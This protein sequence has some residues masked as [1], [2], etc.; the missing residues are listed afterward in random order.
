MTEII[1][2]PVEEPGC[3]CG[4][5]LALLIGLVILIIIALPGGSDDSPNEPLYVPTDVTRQVTTLNGWKIEI[6]NAP[7]GFDL[8]FPAI[9]QCRKNADSSQLSQDYLGVW[10]FRVERQNRWI[11]HGEALIILE[12][13][14]GIDL[15]GY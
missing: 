6:L 12:S 7:S 11:K 14:S 8:A 10:T 1:I 5:G 4:C 2:K 15:G 3:G 13:G 9:I